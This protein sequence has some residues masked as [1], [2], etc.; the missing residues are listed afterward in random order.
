MDVPSLSAAFPS[1]QM[2]MLDDLNLVLP[3][4]DSEMHYY[5]YPIDDNLF[6]QYV[7]QLEAGA[8]HVAH[9]EGMSTRSTFDSV[10]KCPFNL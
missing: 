10:M 6:G 5:S 9:S 1:L 7:G 8:T 2:D 4:E 3:P